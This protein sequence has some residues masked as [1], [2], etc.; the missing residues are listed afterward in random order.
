VNMVKDMALACLVLAGV[1]V[2]SP[3]RAQVPVPAQAFVNAGAA[4]CLDFDLP[5]TAQNPDGVTLQIWQCPPGYGTQPNQRWGLIPVGSN[6]WAI[7][8]M[9][10]SRCIAVE[11][12]STA[13]AALLVQRQCDFNNPSQLWSGSLA[14]SST[15]GRSVTGKWVNV[16]SGK[17]M[18]APYKTNGTVLQQYDCHPSG[19]WQQDF[20]IVFPVVGG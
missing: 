1:L 19:W 5:G 12:D 2:Q 13:N 8:N 17:C 3:A 9:A 11:G 18:D 10:T 7:Q 6:A 4:K 20:F 16:R 15:F 14:P